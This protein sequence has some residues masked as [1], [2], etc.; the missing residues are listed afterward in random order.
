MVPA[1]LGQQFA[2]I[3]ARLLEVRRQSQADFFTAEEVPDW[4]AA[5]VSDVGDRFLLHLCQFEAQVIAKAVNALENM[6]AFVALREKSPSKAID[7]LADFGADITM[8]F[9]G[10]DTVFAKAPL[11]T[12]TQGVFLDASRALA[13]LPPGGETGMLTLSV[14]KPEGQRTFELADFL[15]G[16]TPKAEDV[17]LQQR[18]VSAFR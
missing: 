13:L 11:R 2:S 16:D 12:V 10:L 8:A 4:I 6:Q 9:N 17:L 15:A 1:R 3:R 7:R 14:L 5:A 18:L